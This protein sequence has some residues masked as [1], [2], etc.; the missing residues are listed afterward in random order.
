MSIPAGSSP[1]AWI[2]AAEAATELNV[3]RATLYAYVSRGLVE[4]RG[5]PGSRRRL[6]AAADIRRLRSAGD[7]A[8]TAPDRALDFGT[9]LLDSAITLIDGGRLYYRGRDALAL[10][11][12]ATLETVAGLLWQVDDADPFA[13]VTVGAEPPAAPGIAGAIAR[14]AIAARAD[15]AAYARTAPAL[16]RTGA[17]IVRHLVSVWAGGPAA[18]VVAPDG[19]AHRVLAQTWGV[20]A[21]AEAIRTALV[22]FADHELNASAFAVRVAAS[23]RATPYAA[24]IA[25]LATLEGPRHGGMTPQTLA[26]LAEAVRLGDGR[27]A[28][29]ERL[30][31]GESLPGFGHQLYPDGDPRAR[32]ILAAVRTA[33]GPQPLLDIIA[34]TAD[35]GREATGLAP[36]V[37]F[38]LATLAATWGLDADQA[39]G[40]F[41][42]G[43]SVGWLAHAAEQAASGTLIR[44]RA[45]YVG[46]D[47]RP[48]HANRAR[49]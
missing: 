16:A 32:A 13:G 30:R 18:D 27:A 14:L 12:S 29:T 24:V 2:S 39:I 21:A 3:S 25:G 45:R 35:A 42:I 6:Y 49:A 44:P 1:R 19:P 47:P 28:V 9:P 11:E 36:N 41:A 22:L 43:R 34:A 26:L 17:R 15:V 38:A 4:S 46:P 31:R 48:A 7:G 23:T 5:Q 33:T 40:I 8:A 20:P 37:D 10:A